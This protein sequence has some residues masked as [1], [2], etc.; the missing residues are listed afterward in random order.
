MVNKGQ[1]VAL[2]HPE[3]LSNKQQRV[4]DHHEN[5]QYREFRHRGWLFEGPFKGR[6]PR[7]TAVSRAENL[8]EPTKTHQKPAK[9]FKTLLKP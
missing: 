1:N 5:E 3:L 2:R 8:R 9:T 7:K 4:D 6:R